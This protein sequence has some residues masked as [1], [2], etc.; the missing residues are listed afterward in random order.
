MTGDSTLTVVLVYPDLLGLYGDRG[1]A[2]TLL[3]GARARGVDATLLQVEAGAAVPECGDVYL[4]G[5]GEDA[6][7]LLAGELLAAQP[8]L[9]R[10][11]QRGASCLAV[12]AGF[13]LLADEYA[14]TDGVPRRGLGVLDVRCGRLPGARAVG[15]VLC[16]P[17]GHPWGLISGFE[18]HQG[19][20]VLGPGVTPLG[21]VVHGTGNGHDRQ[22][23]AVS[24]G[25]VAT[26]LHGPVLARNPDLADHLLATA[27]GD[28]ELPPLVEPEVDRLRRERIRAHRRR[29]IWSRGSDGGPG[30]L[31]LH[32]GRTSTR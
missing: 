19:D 15:E 32:G 9:V 10:A 21:H 13:Q 26:Y 11:V 25:V 30:R 27:M 1:N 2:L 6:P 24:G 16:E 5:G 4:V 12:C 29:W 22:E 20:A 3:H 17:V 7:M 23:G 31:A 28:Q 8:A 18:N 14:G